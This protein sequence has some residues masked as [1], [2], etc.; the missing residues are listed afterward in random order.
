MNENRI[1]TAGFS[2]PDSERRYRNQWSDEPKLGAQYEEGGQCG[3]CA[4]FAPFNSDW[5]LCCNGESRHM[6]E[7]V[8]EHFTCSALVDEGWGAH[9][10]SGSPRARR[11]NAG[12]VEADPHAAS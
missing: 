1:V 11:D 7:T 5:G 3:G 10:F 6:T 2:N 8:F 4:Y 12:D 9:S